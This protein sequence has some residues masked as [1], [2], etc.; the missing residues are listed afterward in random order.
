MK[1]LLC[2]HT[3]ATPDVHS[4]EQRMLPVQDIDAGPGDAGPVQM[5]PGEQVMTQ[6]VV[7]PPNVMQMLQEHT[8]F[9]HQQGKPACHRCTLVPCCHNKG[10]AAAASAL[11]LT[12]VHLTSV[13]LSVT[14]SVNVQLR[15]SCV[16]N[17]L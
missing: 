11:V 4:T 8:A 6:H 3:T 9:L 14:A 12:V 5:P 13:C 15:G 7:L 16:T 1:G 2:L 17:F 10:S